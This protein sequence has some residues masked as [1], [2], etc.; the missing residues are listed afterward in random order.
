[1]HGIPLRGVE[2]GRE[3]GGAETGG[4]LFSCHFTATSFPSAPPEQG[5]REGRVSPEVA[6]GWCEGGEFG[7]G[8]DGGEG[9]G[10]G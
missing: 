2:A 5:Q 10:R 6:G 9:S 4:V 3:G 1:M 8:A 7:L